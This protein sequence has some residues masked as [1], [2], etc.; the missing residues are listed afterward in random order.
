MRWLKFSRSNA[1]LC[2]IIFSKRCRYDECEEEREREIWFWIVIFPNPFRYACLFLL[3]QV[4]RRLRDTLEICSLAPSMTTC[5][6]AQMATRLWLDQTNYESQVYKHLL[7]LPWKDRTPLGG[8]VFSDLEKTTT[9]TTDLN[10]IGVMWCD[11]GYLWDNPA[12]EDKD[13]CSHFHNHS[14]HSVDCMDISRYTQKHNF[15]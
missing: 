5:C 13:G 14:C 8:N 3:L 9:W 12:T 4:Q 15:I 10:T 11:G 2:F 1:W 6:S 7:L